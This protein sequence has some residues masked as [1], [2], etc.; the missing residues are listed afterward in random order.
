MEEYVPYD[1]KIFR[2]FHK[3]SDLDR[4]LI[5]KKYDKYLNLGKQRYIKKVP[6]K[7]KI[8]VCSIVLDEPIPHN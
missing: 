6:S 1:K 2:F 3:I 7:W 8:L 4:Y 5:R